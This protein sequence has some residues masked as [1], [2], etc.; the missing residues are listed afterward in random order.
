MIDEAI[1]RIVK[2]ELSFLGGTVDSLKRTITSLGGKIDRLEETITSLGG[3]VDPLKET[4]TS[5]GGKVDPLEETITSLG[6]KIDSLEEGLTSLG[7]IAGLLDNP[8]LMND[9]NLSLGEVV[10]A[11]GVATKQDITNM[12]QEIDSKLSAVQ[13]QVK[14]FGGK[15]Y[16]TWHSGQT[17]VEND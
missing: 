6:G 10:V 5:L 13:Q 14:A 11:A 16:Y 12:A 4:I 17:G 2:Q 3:K 15:G 8:E 1:R 9:S 7:R